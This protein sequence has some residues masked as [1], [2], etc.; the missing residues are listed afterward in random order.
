MHAFLAQA[1]LNLKFLPIPIPRFGVWI[2]T[3]RLALGLNRARAAASLGVRKDLWELIEEQGWVPMTK[4]E[5]FL[6]ALAGV[7]EVRYDDLTCAIE[8]L[9]GQFENAQDQ[10]TDEHHQEDRPAA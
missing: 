5:N 8:P 1:N 6:R 2:R 9:E 3:R 10:P 7:L 4:N